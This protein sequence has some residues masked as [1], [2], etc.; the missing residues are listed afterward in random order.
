MELSL[1]EPTLED[2]KCFIKAMQHSSALHHPWV[3]PA[4]TLA[5]YKNYIEHYQ[6]PNQNANLLIANS[7]EIIGVF[8]LSEIVMGCFQNAYLG[9]FA[10]SGFEGRGLMSQGLKLVMQKAFTELNLHRLEAN[11]QSENLSSIQLIKA[12]GFRH[13]GFSP[14]YLLIEN[15]WRDHERFAITKEDFMA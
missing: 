8:N 15:A 6:K 14:R 1:R 2:G 10:V 7:H 11:I 4:K 13:E 5:D 9:F 3:N 12:N